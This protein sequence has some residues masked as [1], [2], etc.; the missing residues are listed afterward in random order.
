M[1]ELPKGRKLVSS[2]W[3]FKLKELLNGKTKYKARLVARGFSQKEGID[4]TETFAPVVKYKSVRLV[5]AIACERNMHI[6]QMDVCTAFLHGKLEEEIYMTPPEGIDSGGKVWKLE[7]TLYGLKQAPRCWNQRLDDFFVQKGYVQSIND[8]ATYTKGSGK[9]QIIIAIYVDDLLIMSE[10]LDIVKSAK[11]ELT[12]EFEMVDFGEAQ[13][14]LG[15]R[16]KHDRT[17]GIL[18]LDQENY[19]KKILERFNMKD[20]KPVSTPLV[21]GQKL[22]ETRSES[23]KEL[24][25]TPYRSAIGSLMYL[26]VSTRPD[27][28]SAI[29]LLSRYMEGRNST[30]WEA[31][32]RVFRYVQA[33]KEYGL[34]FSREGKFNLVG[35]C[36]ADWG[37]CLDTRRS[38]TGYVFLLGGGAVSW[39]SKRQQSV[40]LSSCEAEYVAAAQAAKEGRWLFNFLTEI[41]IPIT[42]PLQVYSDSQSALALMRNPVYHERSKHI[43]MK[44]HYIRDEIRSKE[45]KFLYVQTSNQVADSLTKAV[46]K[47]KVDFC[48]FHMGVC[49]VHSVHASEL[50]SHEK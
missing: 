29:G 33:T 44:F 50:V 17:L 7:K 35:Y 8:F 11:A 34:K 18:T 15:M 3:V 24:K 39:S 23:V 5:L 28:A 12:T 27:L 22:R 46:P 19:C 10:S 40:A 32:K 42:K 31:V 49:N 6:H 26:M 2:K 41:G 25:D 47:E 14:V 1:C 43:D 48:R 36:D 20:C 16:I 38:T 13:L 21:T 9:E 4:Y 45:M 37:G 30:Q